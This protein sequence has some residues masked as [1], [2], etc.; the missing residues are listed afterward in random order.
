VKANDWLGEIIKGYRLAAELGFSYASRSFL[1]ERIS[2]TAPHERVVIKL[3][4]AADH[5]TQQEQERI[6]QELARLQQLNHPHVL[7]ILSAG[8][9]KGV[10]YSITE[11]LSSESLYDHLQRN[12]PGQP[13]PEEQALS[14]LAQLGQALH[15]AHQ[16]QIVYGRLNPHNVLFKTADQVVVTDFHLS[17]LLPPE[18]AGT[19]D[20]FDPSIYLAPEQFSG[21]TN[22][23]S[24]QYALGC[25]A[26]EMLTGT[27]VF[28]IPSVKIPG[29]Y[30]TTKSL[31]QPRQL[32][33]AVPVHIEEAILKALS[34]DP[35]KRFE[36]IAAFLA[37]L[38]L[39]ATTEGKKEEQEVTANT[40]LMQPL[41]ADV[42]GAGTRSIPGEGSQ[43][44]RANQ[45]QRAFSFPTSRQGLL[46]HPRRR[47]FVVILCLL[48]IAV[49]TGTLI[50][51]LLPHSPTTASVLS[52]TPTSVLSATPTSR[53]ATPKPSPSALHRPSQ[54]TTSVQNTVIPTTTSANTN[55]TPVPMPTPM[56]ASAAA[57]STKQSQTSP[58]GYW[59]FDEGSGT[60]AADASG[61]GYTAILQSGASWAPGVV[62]SSS[63]SLNGNS[64]SYAD[65]S[66]PVVNT[67]ASFSVAAWVEVNAITKSSKSY[68]TFVSLDGSS[69]SA[70]YLQ[71]RGDN[72]LFSFTRTDSDSTTA[73]AATA[74]SSFLP[75]A[76]VWYHLA[77]VYDASA[78]TI[79]LYV[80]GSL[81]Q[82]VS[83]TSAW[84]GNGHTAIGRGWFY[85]HTVDFVNGQID[86]VR[87]YNAALN[88][89]QIQALAG[90]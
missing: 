90:Q 9:H 77:G 81:Q 18:K 82:T 13:L 55:P 50:N 26:Y 15:Y 46:R 4:Y 40:E 28:L 42:H 49:G 24:D 22:P 69:V 78:Q 44:L 66:Q 61:N 89:S 3:W 39:S 64:D 67:A 38:G 60:T 83:Y 8:I 16:Q 37:A 52:A 68:Q 14:L 48:A 59:K 58:V 1:G 33:L 80:N 56:L 45:T 74:S 31:I 73:A 21:D 6:R 63:L 85:R 29:K 62:G 20:P 5:R 17:I 12:P 47:V 11:Y 51:L 41:L 75:N 88:A 71:L 32:N 86:D 36:D 72:S 23:K 65:I 10:P 70:F 57:P 35:A 34:R 84:Q 2:P 25:L 53:S 19:T 54:T 79:S 76:G 87:I 27:K 30:Y 7:P 43:A